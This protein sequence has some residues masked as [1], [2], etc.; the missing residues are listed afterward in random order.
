MSGSLIVNQLI[1]DGFLLEHIKMLTSVF[2]ER[3]DAMCSALDTH[4]PG[5][6]RVCRKHVVAY[7]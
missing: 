3:I 1:T 5:K 6:R 2:A 7:M 4:L